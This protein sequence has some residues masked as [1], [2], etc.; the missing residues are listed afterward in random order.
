MVANGFVNDH[1]D[2]HIKGRMTQTLIRSVL[3][4]GI[5]NCKLTNDDINKIKKTEGIILKR[6]LGISKWSIT[7]PLYSSLKIEST[8]NYI[9]RQKLIF[10]QRLQLN[11]YTNKVINEI[12]SENFNESIIQDVTEILLLQPSTKIEI[13]NKACSVAIK[14][15]EQENDDYY[16]DELLTKNIKRAFNIKRPR[17]RRFILNKLLMNNGA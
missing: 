8:F 15:I 13:I 3:M 2:P 17:V 10:F 11:P 4:Y 5:E 16:K 7:T 12:A 9:K 14:K 1:L 6:L